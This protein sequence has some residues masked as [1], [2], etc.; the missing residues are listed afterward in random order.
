MLLSGLLAV[1]PTARL[2]L[3]EH[4]HEIILH[5]QQLLQADR[6]ARWGSRGV[7]AHGACP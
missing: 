3:H 4:S 5:G 1:C 7:L 2:I 6:R